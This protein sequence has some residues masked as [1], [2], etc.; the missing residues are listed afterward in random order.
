MN[1]SSYQQRPT[2]RAADVGESARFMNI[3]L[4]LS[5]FPLSDIFY[6]R[7]PSAANAIRWATTC[8]KL[9]EGYFNGLHSRTS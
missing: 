6:P 3:F 2:K 5:V 8:L 9:F 4:A 7:P 1:E